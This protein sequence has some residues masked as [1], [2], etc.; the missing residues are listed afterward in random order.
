MPDQL[1][2]N[3]NS[4]SVMFPCFQEEAKP[5]LPPHLQAA[6]RNNPG[7]AGSGNKGEL[8]WLMRTTYISNDTADRRHQGI[9]EKR[10]RATKQAQA[11]EEAPELDSLEAQMQT[12][13][14]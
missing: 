5:A 4:L 1:S 8:S 12:I 2:T 10:A 7:V 13:E 11:A 9:S 6:I 3:T 14:V